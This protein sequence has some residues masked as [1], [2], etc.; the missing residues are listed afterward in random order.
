MN[1][2]A[3]ATINNHG[4]ITYWT[5]KHTEA[6][7]PAVNMNPD[8]A[9]HFSCAREAYWEGAIAKG[10]GYFRAVRVY[11]TPSKDGFKNFWWIPEE[12]DEDGYE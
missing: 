1:E 5:G 6:N 4:T 11:Y 7:K 2:Y 9:R 8:K 12:D 3:L 10:I